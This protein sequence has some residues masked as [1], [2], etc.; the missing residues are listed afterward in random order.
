MAQV[1]VA[2]R[3]IGVLVVRTTQQD[4]QSAVNLRRENFGTTSV[5]EQNRNNELSWHFL[6]MKIYRQGANR[7][8]LPVGIEDILN[9]SKFSSPECVRIVRC[10]D[11]FEFSY[12]GWLKKQ[13]HFPKP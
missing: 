6:G 12:T 9:F 8:Q 13:P 11:E 2:Q 5:P 10:F 7:I 3:T 1:R 4:V